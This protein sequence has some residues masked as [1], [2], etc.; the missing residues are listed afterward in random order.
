M[1]K[2]EIKP[3]SLRSKITD[4]SLTNFKVSVIDAKEK[5]KLSPNNFVYEYSLK[6][7]VES[8]I[9]SVIVNSI[10][11]IYSNATK[12]LFLAEIETSGV[13][14]IE[15]FEEVTEHQK[16]LIP[17][18][19]LSMFG[20]VLLSTTRGFL[21]MRSEETIVKGAVLPMINVNSFFNQPENIKIVPKSKGKLTTSHE[22]NAY[23]K[24]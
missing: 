18:A 12:E 24:K 5:N 1:K 4:I 15:N 9:S 23:P 8:K 11:K 21:I 13:F 22:K 7:Q 3:L 19:I 6:F 14:E 10:V 20:G 17:N 16:G 2:E